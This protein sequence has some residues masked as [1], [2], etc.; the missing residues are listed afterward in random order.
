MIL[1]EQ[2]STLFFGNYLP[3]LL[4]AAIYEGLIPEGSDMTDLFNS[5]LDI[6][7]AARNAIFESDDLLKNYKE[8]NT[9]FLKTK[10]PG[11]ADKVATGLFKDFVILKQGKEFA[12]FMD[13]E[14]KTFY[15]VIAI[16][17][18]FTELLDFI[19]AY[20]KTA[21][22]NFNDKLIC[23]GLIT[24]SVNIGPNH[25]REFLDDY[26]KALKTKKAVKL[27]L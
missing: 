3:L 15:H 6:K 4:Y 9:R 13:E 24:K 8:D 26:K 12:V 27:L 20:V 17:D 18:P 22:F 14:T 16:T 10:T 19:P 23:D 1:S 2:D 5:S 7:V 25:E 21:I 11:F